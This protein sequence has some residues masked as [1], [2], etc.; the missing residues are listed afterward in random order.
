MNTGTDYVSESV[1]DTPVPI[2]GDAVA[3]H[4]WVIPSLQAVHI[5]CVALILTSSL[6]IGLRLAGV[7][8]SDR[9]L[10]WFADRFLGWIWAPLGV[11][12]VTG[13]L[14]ITAEPRRSLPNSVF[15][16]KMLLLVAAV[17]VMAIFARAVRNNS[18]KWG[19]SPVP[20]KL[21]GLAMMALWAAIAVSGRLI[22]Y[23]S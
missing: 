3:N 20:A 4:L 21:L 9:P 22:A 8:G 12:L 13:A 6:F 10:R 7:A 15:Q 11:L 5:V 1:G 19:D 18:E 14:L 23:I 2:I 16:T 17:V